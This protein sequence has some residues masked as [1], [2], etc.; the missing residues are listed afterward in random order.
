MTPIDS[1]EQQSDGRLRRLVKRRKELL[2]E[3]EEAERALRAIDR[4][5]LEKRI[6]QQFD[7]DL[8]ERFPNL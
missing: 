2:A 8:L 1:G 6:E 3:I 5:L 7:S 4:V